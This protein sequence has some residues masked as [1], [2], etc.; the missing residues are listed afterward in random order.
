MGTTNDPSVLCPVGMDING[1]EGHNGVSPAGHKVDSEG[2]RALD[3]NWTGSG[4]PPG[5]RLRGRWN[6]AQ[7]GVT[8]GLA[9]SGLPA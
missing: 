7:G 5:W 9:F 8:V 3:R 4:A 1:D 6:P 2:P